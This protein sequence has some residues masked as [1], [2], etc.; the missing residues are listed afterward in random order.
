MAEMN[1]HVMQRQRWIETHMNA[2]VDACSYILIMLLQRLEKLQP[3]LLNEMIAGVEGDRSAIPSGI[4]NGEHID[5]IFEETL[6]ML[7][8]ANNT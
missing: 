2:K 4:A 1:L 7:R 6:R 8:Q 5:A 3:G